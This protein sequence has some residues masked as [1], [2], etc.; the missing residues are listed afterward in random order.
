MTG[1]RRRSQNGGMSSGFRF[2][3]S[4]LKTDG[5]ASTGI[6]RARAV[7]ARAGVYKYSDGI[8]Q[9]MEY[10]PARVLQDQAWVDSV[11][12]SPVT[13]NHPSE[14]VTAQNARD[15][16]VGAVGDTVLAVDGENSSAIAVW[17]AD[18]VEK[19]RTTHQQISMGYWA[20]VKEEAGEFNGVAYQF[21]QV[22]RRANHVA[23]VE[24]GRHGSSVRLALDSAGWGS[25]GFETEEQLRSD[26]ERAPQPKQEVKM[27]QI[28]LGNLTLD[29]ADAGTATSIQAYV[30]QAQADLM[31]VK[32]ASEQATKRADQA[33][34]ARDAAKAELDKLKSDSGSVHADQMKVARARV[35]LEERATEVLGK[36]VKLDGLSDREVQVLMLDK[37]G[38][39]LD[40]DKS[41]DYVAARLDAL[42]DLTERARKVT[43]QPS[44]A[45]LLGR[46]KNDQAPQQRADSGQAQGEQLSPNQ[47]LARK[48]G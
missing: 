2:Q 8:R 24:R 1:P 19:A 42:G 25:A 14:P 30:D 34:A 38:V 9:W 22:S 4:E 32:S 47:A 23:L 26:D 45:E 21:V 11:K 6:L 18:A 3:T 40:A 33:E 7:L 43:P 17:T 44:V 28:R 39:K 15:L 36:D 10:T 5:V 37:L 31:N 35:K 27:P 16:A 46:A 20:D 41:D 48:W 29:V 13:I 12:L